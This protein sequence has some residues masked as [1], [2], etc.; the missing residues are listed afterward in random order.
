MKW[1]ESNR[2]SNNQTLIIMWNTFLDTMNPKYQDQEWR[3]YWPTSWHQPKR[4]WG[5]ER[6][7][8]SARGYAGK[9]SLQSI[10]SV[11]WELNSMNEV[12][13]SVI[14]QSNAQVN[15]QIAPNL[16]NQ[17]INNV[18]RPFLPKWWIQWQPLSLSQPWLIVRIWNHWPQR[19]WQVHLIDHQ[20]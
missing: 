2:L 19:W 13:Q 15:S 6:W 4:Y 5:T 12:H 10:W 16:I 20:R 18:I 14:T 3:L 8:L 9:N 7:R 11:H 17:S 1:N